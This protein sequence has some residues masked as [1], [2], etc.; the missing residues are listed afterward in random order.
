MS[1]STEPKLISYLHSKGIE[2]GIPVSGTFELTSRC[3]FRCEMCYVHGENCKSKELSAEEWIAL[4]ERAKDAGTVFLLLTGGEPLLRDDF[5]RIYSELGKMGFVLS[6]NTNGSL[7]HNYLDLFTSNPPSRINISL[8]GAD[9]ATYENLCKTDKFS[10][11]VENIKKLKELNIPVKINTVLTDKNA[12]QCK[13]IIS[14]AHEL[15]VQ[16]STTAYAYP[17]VRLNDDYGLNST[18]LSYSE[19]AKAT[20]DCELFRYGKEAFLARASKYLTLSNG[21]PVDTVRCRAGRSSFWITSQGI[22][23][24]CGMLPQL[25]AMPLKS[26]FDAAW[27]TVKQKTKEVRLPLECLRCKFSEICRACAA[28]CYA[29]TGAF[30]KKPEYVC[31]LAEEIYNLTLK[32]YNKI[33][34][35]GE[36]TDENQ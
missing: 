16:I 27:E 22:M 20:V 15:G 33:K 30:D 10:V 7:V 23:R 4:G 25:E 18:R 13:K 24:A 1:L 14:L 8:Y 35:E 29:E 32:E 19:A 11:V 34:S 28:M 21:M 2:K 9:G 36:D 17:Q 6:L 12:H 3:N 5:R 31:K 26:G